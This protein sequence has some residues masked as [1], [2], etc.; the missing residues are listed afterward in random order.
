MPRSCAAA[1]GVGR[2]G[3]EMCGPGGRERALAI[4]KAPQALAGNQLG[5]TEYGPRARSVPTKSSARA[6]ESRAPARKPRT[7]PPITDATGYYVPGWARAASTPASTSSRSSPMSAPAPVPR[8]AAVV[9]LG[10]LR[11]CGATAA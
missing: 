9:S 6:P 2:L 1:E 11:G 7:A 4:E 5:H 3:D 10:A 8:P